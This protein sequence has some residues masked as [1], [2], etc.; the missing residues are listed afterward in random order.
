MN[1]FKILL[2]E[3]DLLFRTMLEDHLSQNPEYDVM[4]VSCGEE[5]IA[6]LEVEP[7]LI[8][9]DYNMDSFNRQAANGLTTLKIIKRLKPNIPVIMLSGEDDTSTLAKVLY[10]GAY[11]YVVKG[12]DAFDKVSTIIEEMRRETNIEADFRE[13]FGIK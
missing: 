3:D 2:V 9:M 4:M 11:N 5:C 12:D 13:N 10:S 1:T 6:N 8:I 7:H